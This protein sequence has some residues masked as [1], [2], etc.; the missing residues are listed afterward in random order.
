M[1]LGKV[2]YVIGGKLLGC[3]LEG[4]GVILIKAKSRRGQRVVWAYE[5]TITAGQDFQC[6]LILWLILKIKDIFK[7]NLNLMLFIQKTACIIASLRMG[8][9]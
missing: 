9:M 2:K 6:C 8:H 1:L 5:A 3:M 7:M 4:K